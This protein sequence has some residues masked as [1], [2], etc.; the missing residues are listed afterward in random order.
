MS[1]TKGQL[2][3]ENAVAKRPFYEDGTPRK[4][5]DELPDYAKWS[6]ESRA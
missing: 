4:T 6:W 3:Y 5:W 1:K 2:D